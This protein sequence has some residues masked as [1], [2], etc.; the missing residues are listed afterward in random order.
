MATSKKSQEP[1]VD[2][3][4]LETRKVK[5]LEKIA[6]SLESLTVW[7]EEIEKDEWSNRIQYYLSE[8]HKVIVKKDENLNE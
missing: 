4:Q 8:F 5:A 1:Q 6:N 7:V 3:V 2:L